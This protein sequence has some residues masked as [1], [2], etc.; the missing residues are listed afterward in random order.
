MASPALLTI[1]DVHR[2]LHPLLATADRVGKQ[3]E[4]FAETLDRIS[5]KKQQKLQ[6]D[7][8][9]VLPL[10]KE[11]ERIADE[12]VKR[13]RKYHEP[14]RQEKWKKSW[15]RRLRSSSGRSTPISIHEDDNV[16]ESLHTTLQDLQRWEQE[17]QTWQLFGLMIEIEH[18][19]HESEI[20]SLNLARPSSRPRKDSEIHRFS[21]EK[22]IWENF[23]AEDDAAWE[24]NIVVEWLKSSAESS[25]QDV[26]VIIE[27]LDTGADRGSGLWA[28][29]WLYSKEAIK[30]KKRLRSWP[31]PLDPGSPGIDASLGNV[32]RARGL[33]TQLDPDAVTRQGR[34][35]EKEDVFFERATW[36]ACW[37]FLRRGRSW[38][39]IRQW[40]QDRVEVWRAISIQGDPRGP[41]G[42]ENYGL[43]QAK[44]NWQSRSL[45][46]RMCATAA[47]D[48]GSDKYEKAV[49]GMLA[50]YFPSV[51]QVCRSWD[52]FLFAHYNT[53][54]L[55]QFDQYL[56]ARFP[57]RLS[58]V[59]VE[60]HVSYDHAT[61]GGHTILSSRAVV[62]KLQRL[63][64]I[65][66]EANQPL[67]M[68]QGSII[69]KTFKDFVFKHGVKLARSANAQGRSK[70]MVDMDD[71]FLDQG[72]VADI[73]MND[74]DL[75]RILTHM[76]FILQDLGLATE[77]GDHQYAT[78]NI[79]VAYVDYLGKAGKQQLLPL[80]AS[81][82]S[83]QRSIECMG[84]Q[85]PSILDTGERKTVMKLM[86]QYG[87]NLTGV[88]NMQLRMIILDTPPNP[89]NTGAIPKLN[90][91]D[92][93]TM[94]S[95]VIRAV[96]SG[97]LGHTMSGDEEDLLHGF[98]W[99]MLL[100]EH[101]KETMA[102][103]TII[104]KH[105]LRKFNNPARAEDGAVIPNIRRTLGTRGLAAARELAKSI[106][107]SSI[108]LCKTQLLLGRTLDLSQ[109]Q[110]LDDIDLENQPDTRRNTRSRQ[111]KARPR[112]RSSSSRRLSVR[113]ELL[114]NESNTFRDFESLF[115]A[116]D[117][118]EHWKDV[119]DQSVK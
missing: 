38:D 26:D 83:R 36:L 10:V 104:Y 63:D 19:I 9:H 49:Y 85:L 31:Q 27:Q 4:E 84:R 109:N 107:F 100:E 18:P 23:L 112:R 54:L 39:S 15:R 73:G 114:L 8:R 69:A 74:H 90:I 70:I 30:S 66:D 11:Y 35:L 34:S 87:M 53:Y 59:V 5:I 93:S 14:E 118:L 20:S 99:Y 92:Q 75:L 40:C 101:W 24:R 42:A 47:K 106:T 16:N 119:I 82:L 77:V 22:V 80:Y 37:E 29:G 43:A 71:D 91:L 98:E 94:D 110:L 60:K 52:D 108:S 2:A 41:S 32:E 76:L 7:C 25:G 89:Q 97:F 50:G 58:Q 21:T 46:R 96:K 28:H 68:L 78:E 116:L 45:W 105:L 72:T 81:R 44:G 113:R 61:I 17:R 33:V 86:Q 64:L 102:T 57:E 65:K 55:H 12:T 56:Q 3:V 115:V 103:G 62:E 6:K 67:K 51:E 48:G 117:A 111:H 95:K 79:I 13:L 88:L 1:G